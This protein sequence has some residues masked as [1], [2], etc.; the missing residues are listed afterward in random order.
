[1]GVSRLQGGLKRALLRDA[2]GVIYN[3]DDP[4]PRLHAVSRAGAASRRS[5]DL[6]AGD[7]ILQC[8]SPTVAEGCTSRRDL[9]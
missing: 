2:S 4:L 9:Q 8:E 6:R 3:Q 7:R 5:V 1:M